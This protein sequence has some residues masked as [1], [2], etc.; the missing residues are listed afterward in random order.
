MSWSIVSD[1]RLTA[2]SLRDTGLGKENERLRSA[3][4]NRQI[5]RANETTKQP[6]RER[7]MRHFLEHHTCDKEMRVLSMP[8]LYWP[9][10]KELIAA[11][12]KPIHFVGLE[13]NWGTIELGAGH[14]PRNVQK[15]PTYN[16]LFLGSKKDIKCF[17]LQTDI[18]HWVWMHASTFMDLRREDKPGKSLATWAMT[19][20]RNTAIWLDVNSNFGNE[21]ELC[22]RRAAAHCGE[23]VPRVP[24]ALT[25]VIGQEHED[26]RISEIDGDGLERRLPSALMFLNSGSRIFELTEHWTYLSEAGARMGNILGILH[27]RK[28]AL[29]SKALT[30]SLAPK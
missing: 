4:S 7:V 2:K 9:F 1:E 24:F 13:W 18:A 25:F 20:K 23:S 17:S 8:G 26:R 3:Y 10:E 11:W 14:M 15:R 27:K 12:N 19:Y 21:V 29:A 16:R 5:Y 22:L 30:P 6:Q 28:S